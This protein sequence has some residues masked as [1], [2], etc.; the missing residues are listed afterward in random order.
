MKSL[1]DAIVNF[2]EEISEAQKY[3]FKLYDDIFA[4]YFA[5]VLK[6]YDKVKQ[7]SKPISDTDLE[8]ILTFVPLDMCVINE[9]IAPIELKRDL[10]KHALKYGNLSDDDKWA[11]HTIISIYDNIL[12]RVQHQMSFCREFIMTAKKIWDRR[13]GSEEASPISGIRN[14]SV[15]SDLPEY[16]H[17]VY[18]R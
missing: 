4:K 6:L 16:Q 5:D 11:N 15:D 3:A 8:Y 10:A 7:D 14:D 9:S 18:I 2:D 1:S 17:N 13:K 12:N